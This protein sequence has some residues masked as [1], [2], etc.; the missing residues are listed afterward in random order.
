MQNRFP[1]YRRNILEHDR[2]VA[3]RTILYT[4]VLV[5]S[6]IPVERIQQEIDHKIKAKANTSPLL[7][8]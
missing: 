3:S 5:S 1:Q 6:D 4:T 2:V 7:C 8:L